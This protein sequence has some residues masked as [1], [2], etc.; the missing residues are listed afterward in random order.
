MLSPGNSHP[1][2][3]Y[4]ETAPFWPE[5]EHWDLVR[6]IGPTATTQPEGLGALLCPTLPLY[7]STTDDCRVMGSKPTPA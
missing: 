5:M 2:V 7:P 3:R 6:V 1:F 4:T